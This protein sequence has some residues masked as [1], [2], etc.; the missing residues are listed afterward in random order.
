MLKH[1]KNEFKVVKEFELTK[2]FDGS[3]DN[4]LCLGGKTKKNST[5][6]ILSKSILTITAVTI[7]AYQR[8]S[9]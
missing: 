9:F 1:L 8:N 5:D 4:S 6:D 2:H 7:T 3:A